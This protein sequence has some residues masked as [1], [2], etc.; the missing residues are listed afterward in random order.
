MGQPTEPKRTTG[1]E[2]AIALIQ[3][4]LKGRSL[5][6][7]QILEEEAEKCKRYMVLSQNTHD[8]HEF[9]IEGF[10]DDIEG[11][12]ALVTQIDDEWTLDS[13]SDLHSAFFGFPVTIKI[14]KGVRAYVDGI[15]IGHHW[16]G[17]RS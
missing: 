8:R 16:E 1:I 7:D 17:N 15:E 14:D 4:V 6:P 5:H 2:Q 9:W 10:S 3:D 12:L 11:A 13:V